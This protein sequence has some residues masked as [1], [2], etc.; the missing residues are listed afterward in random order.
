MIKQTLNLEI[1]EAY[2]DLKAS[3]A[4]KGCKIVSEESPRHILAKQGSL[5]GMSPFTAKKTVDVTLERSSDGTQVTCSS[6]LSSDWRNITI[7]G[8]ILAAVLVGVCLWMTFDLN[9]FTVT[10]KADYWSWLV[11]VDGA[12]D[13]SAAQSLIRL[14]EV[15]AAFLSLVIVL[16]AI[17]TVY[18]YRGIDRFTKD[19]L[20]LPTTPDAADT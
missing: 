13:S 12:L 19:A 5:W 2:V 16:E 6:R 11:T 7:I 17:I 8:C 20:N 10:G 3:L 15:L 1:E 4:R 18:V 14:T 9:A